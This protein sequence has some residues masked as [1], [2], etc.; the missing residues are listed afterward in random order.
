MSQYAAELCTL[1]VE[2]QFGDL[3]GRI[4]LKLVQ[5]GR[6]TLPQLR[7]YAKITHKQALHAVAAMIQMHLLY[8]YLS[9]NDGVTYYEANTHAAY[10]LIRAGKILEVVHKRLGDYEAKVMSTIMYCGHAQ[11]SYLESLAELRIDTAVKLSTN[12]NGVEH[13]EENGE[14][15]DINAAAADDDLPPSTN[16]ANANGANDTHNGRLHAAL[17]SLAGHG[18]ICQ[19]IAQQAVSSASNVKGKEAADLFRARRDEVLVQRTDSSIGGVFLVHG[20]PKGAKRPQTNGTSEGSNKRRRVSS[21]DGA[22]EDFEDE[23]D[24][25]DDNDDEPLNGNIVVRVNYE[26]L[27]VVLRNRRLVDMAAEGASPATVEVYE[28]LLR[29]IEYRTPRCRDSSEIAL[30]G[31]LEL[32]REDE[33]NEVRSAGFTL[34]RLANEID[35]SLDLVSSIGPRGNP[36]SRGKK[37]KVNAMVNGDDNDEFEEGENGITETTRAYDIDQ[38]LNLLQQPPYYLAS[39]RSNGSIPEW[40]VDYRRLARQLRH[41]EIERIVGIRFGRIALRLV[42]IL[43]NKGKLDEKRLQEI[44]LVPQKDM[45]QVLGLMQENGFV[46]L[47]EIPRDSQRVPHRTVFLWFYDPDRIG[48]NLLHDTYKA[49]SRCYQR[50][51]FE[52]NRLKD[53]L[54]KTERIDVKGNEDKY[55]N[56]GERQVLQQW[57]DKEALMLGEIARLD[58]IVAVL[59]DF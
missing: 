38:H 57:R 45:R 15:D 28:G 9:N 46:D 50:L 13:G 40:T 26:K 14:N 52:R 6:L 3:F 16:G 4:F 32:P 41:L 2:D 56:D 49:M 19:R 12:G 18:Y 34:H 58:D 36:Q 24:D 27:D 1:L 43:Q 20:I 39:K 31:S 23:E 42:R 7:G 44:S 10:Y 11:V 5:Y 53:F 17:K 21:F 22:E 8:H 55:L 25:Y 30:Q 48:R 29:L 51:R 33:E 47:Q 59:R 37:N 35:T 54:D